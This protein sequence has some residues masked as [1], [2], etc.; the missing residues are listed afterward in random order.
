MYKQKIEAKKLNTI[1]IILN[2]IFLAL[3]LAAVFFIFR[4]IATACGYVWASII[5]AIVVLPIAAISFMPTPDEFAYTI[6]NDTLTLEKFSEGKLLKS[7][8]IDLKQTS[9]VAGVRGFYFYCPFFKKAYTLVFDGK[10]YVIAPD[11][12]LGKLLNLPS[13]TDDFIDAHK[14]EM[15]DDIAT[16]VSYPSTQQDALLDMPFGEPCALVL[17]KTLE[18]C[19][20]MGMRT[21]NVDNYCGWAEIGEGTHLIGVLCHLD[22]VPE[23]EGWD[24]DPYKMEIKDGF[25]FGRGVADDKGPAVAAIYAVK[26]LLDTNKTLK[27]RIRLIFGCNEESGW[28]CMNRY[29]RSEE[30]PDIAF[31]PDASYPVINNERGIAHL[32]LSTTLSSGFYK[33]L[34]NGGLRAN[35]VPANASATVIGDVE[36]LEDK[37]NNLPAGVEY[38]KEDGTLIFTSVGKSAHGSSPREGKNAVFPLL[39]VLSSLSLGGDQE[40]FFDYA[41][42]LFVDDI[43]G[44]SF[45]ID[46]CDESGPLT[47][48]LGIALIGKNDI[49]PEMTDEDCKI[50]L[51]IRYPFSLS[52]DEL[53]TKIK[54]KIPALWSVEPVHTQPPH[55]VDENSA[56]VTTLMKV[57]AD[58][59]KR[60][61]KLLS[62]GGG[63]YARV[64]PGKAVAFG[65]HF[66]GEAENIHAPNEKKE[67]A[68]LVL[69]AKMFATALEKLANNE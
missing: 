7:V 34:L 50:V 25:I 13:E 47:L 5:G 63:T 18:L 41:S 57:Y 17:Q 26:A 69:S 35:M 53:I 30:L 21:K 11:R 37:L 23:G 31:S 29:K 27:S 14:D 52:L 22:V 32:A 62:I 46:I 2:C 39:S 51:D 49:Y 9:I 66:I 43:T 48:N 45:G 24:T 8:V 28:A 10:A 3:V 1:D 38:K 61:D 58:Y 33:V 36:A 20:N 68:N 59:T 4:A 40:V 65:T 15:L 55:H 64:L 16:L 56:L 6:E 54:D 42:R 60:D 19:E 12:T 44:K 67:I